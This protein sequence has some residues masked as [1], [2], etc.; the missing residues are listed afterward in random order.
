METAGRAAGRGAVDALPDRAHR[1]RR[2]EVDV[3]DEDRRRRGEALDALV[4]HRRVGGALEEILPD[5]VARLEALSHA[6][7][8]VVPAA[9]ASSE[10]FVARNVSSMPCSPRRAARAPG[11]RR[12]GRASS[13]PGASRSCARETSS[14]CCCTRPPS[15]VSSSA[16]ASPGVVRSVARSAPIFAESLPT[17]PIVGEVRAV[18]RLLVVARRSPAPRRRAA[19]RRGSRTRRAPRGGGAASAR[20]PPKLG[21]ARARGRRARTSPDGRLARGRA[22]RSA[23]RARGSRRRRSRNRGCRRRERS[24]VSPAGVVAARRGAPAERP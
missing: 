4:A 23:G 19:R 17:A 13:G 12:R 5:D 18:R 15:R 14:S 21:P 24:R 20:A 1:A 10:S 7:R 2:V 22:R 8:A 9:A 3:R 11:P 16:C 6:P